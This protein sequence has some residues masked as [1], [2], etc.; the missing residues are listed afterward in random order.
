MLFSNENIPA[1]KN[2]TDPC[3]LENSQ[4]FSQKLKMLLKQIRYKREHNKRLSCVLVLC[5]QHTSYLQ[6]IP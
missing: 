2:S 5:I 4:K 1:H 3:S 6:Y